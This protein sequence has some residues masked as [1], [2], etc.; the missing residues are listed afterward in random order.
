VRLLGGLRIG[1]HLVEIDH[2]AVVFGF[3]LGPQRL[4]REDPFPHQL[5]AR[6]V[7]GAVVFH[8]LD[9]PAAADAELETPA[10]QL[11]EAGDLL[12]GDDRVPLG[13]EADAGAE[14]QVFG[15]SRG[16]GQR[17]E[18]VMRVRIALRQF[19]AARGRRAPAD[20]DVGVLGYE[21]R[22]EPALFKRPRQLGDVDA[23]IDRKI[24]PIFTFDF[25]IFAIRQKGRDPSG[26]R[27]KDG[28]L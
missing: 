16:K 12:R 3:V 11:V 18:R 26:R 4:H 10:R 5:E 22:L 1:P 15:D 9:V 28:N 25:S 23:V 2:F 21:Q 17:D 24:D 14:P 27:T 8:L 7:A 20:R 13:N 6:V 19:A